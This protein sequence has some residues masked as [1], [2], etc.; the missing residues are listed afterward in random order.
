MQQPVA[1]SLAI[2]IIEG[3]WEAGTSITLGNI[4][5]RF[6]IS[7]TV[8]REVSHTLES[9]HAV[10]I[11]KRVG[12]VA[13]PL[14]AWQALDDQVIRWK[15]HSNARNRQLASLTELRLAIEP[16]A[17]ADTA[18]HASLETRA[19]M[20]VLAMEM[21][22]SGESGDL[23]TF[24]KLDSR[25]HTLVLTE[26]N[27]ELFAAL[28]PQISTVIVSRVEMGLYPA[29]PKPEALDAHEQVAQAIWKQEPSLASQAMALIVDEV[30]TATE[31]P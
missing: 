29:K 10:I 12:L 17:A 30:K 11:K 19:L 22:K 13:Q 14:E 15:L 1:E 3:R 20:P 16:T 31:R 4:Q 8:A 7:R 5:E 2:D 21:R 23:D 18:R 25:F 26:S 24:H 6:S 28:A 9:A 27:N